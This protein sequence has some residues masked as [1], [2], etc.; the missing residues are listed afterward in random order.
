MPDQVKVEDL[1]TFRTLRAAIHKF[2]NIAQQSL[3]SAQASI[4]RTHA[5][6]ENEQRTHWLSQHKKRTEAVVQAREAVR[7]KKLYK[8]ASGR[9]PSAVEEEK[10]LRRC[11]AA[12]QEAQ[13]KIQ[14]VKK[15]LPRLE[16]ETELYR[17]GTARLAR[18]I[19]AD[20]PHAIALLDRLADSL[21]QYT[22]L[23]A[24]DTTRFDAIAPTAY[25]ESMSRGG[26]VAETQPLAPG[27]AGGQ[28]APPC[29]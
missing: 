15:S 24:P 27:S 16:K 19:T 4:D 2:A 11:L 20:L 10:H 9:T 26:E 12:V 6:L 5:W 3:T 23:E 21:E 28:E 14:A 8:D 18:A 29:P 1:E 25:E 13:D 7:Q 22:Q 17:G